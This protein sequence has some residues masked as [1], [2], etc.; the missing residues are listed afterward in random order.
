L[1]RGFPRDAL[2]VQGTE[3]DA[4]FAFEEVVGHGLIVQ[5]LGRFEGANLGQI[6]IPSRPTEIIQVPHVQS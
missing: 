2:V 4:F 5:V 6:G 3:D 1:Q